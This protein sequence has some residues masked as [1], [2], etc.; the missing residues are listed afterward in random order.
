MNK[1][2]AI[3]LTCTMAIVAAIVGAGLYLSMGRGDAT[4]SAP[5]T[6]ARSAASS[7]APVKVR[8]SERV[9]STI[10]RAYESA[11]RATVLTHSLGTIHRQVSA[12][13]DSQFS[14]SARDSVAN[15]G[16]IQD[17]SFSNYYESSGVTIVDVSVT[18]RRAGR[19]ASTAYLYN[20]QKSD[21]QWKALEID[22]HKE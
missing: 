19:H 10:L 14:Q 11:D 5:P 20:G 7:S 9:V 16:T 13:T 18:Y 2:P 15:N 17:I 3:L 22:P 12:M 21:N 4:P 6:A 1:K 8:A